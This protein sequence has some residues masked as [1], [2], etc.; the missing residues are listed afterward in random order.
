MLRKTYAR[1]SLENIKHNIR[2]IKKGLPDGTQV[3]AVVKADAYGHGAVPISFAALDAGASWLAVALAEEGAELREAG[4]SCPVLVMTHANE[5]QV[6]LAVRYGMEQSVCCAD[7]IFTVEK[8]A[9]ELNREAYVHLKIDTGM[10]RIGIRSFEELQGVLQAF[11][12]CA[13]VRFSGVFTHFSCSDE[14]DKGYTKQQAALFE[15]YLKAVRRGGFSPMV[16]AANSGGAT[17][18]AEYAYDGVRLGISMYGYHPS[19]EKNRDKIGLIPAM[20]VFAEVAAVKTVEEGQAIGYG[21]TFVT[22]RQTRIATVQI[23]YGDGY[24]RLLSNKGS[25]LVETEGGVFHAPVIGRVCMDQTMIDVTQIEGVF[26]GGS[27][28]VMG[29]A[30]Q[31]SI[32]ADDI[33][34]LTGTISYEVVLGFSKRVP[35]VYE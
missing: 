8:V 2:E 32:T 28:V 18:M 33:A 6:R 24:P 9:R 3:M 17:D 29:C 20:E 4:I 11:K 26:A 25:M 1:I 5:A 34:K 27:V 15:E 13:H 16:H 7:D 30:G 22:D 10:G 31:R 35:R 19:G 14:E 12:E 21:G 23:G